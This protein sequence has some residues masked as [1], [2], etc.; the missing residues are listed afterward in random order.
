MLGLGEAGNFPAAVKAVSE[1]F[2]QKDQAFAVGIFNAGTNVA[3][4]I[5]PPVFVAL[6]GHYGWRACFLMT[7][8]VGVVWLI[9]WWIHYRRPAEHS[10]V[11]AAEL[12]YI[13]SDAAKSH[14]PP[15]GWAEALRYRE[16][17]GFALGKFFSDPVWW[18]YLSWLPPY[19]FDVRKL[20]L[21]SIGWALPVIYLAADIGSVGGGWMAGVLIRRGWTVAGARKVCMGLSAACMPVAALCVLAESPFA[22]I[23]LVSLATAAHQSWSANLYATT[24]DVFPRNAVASV[25]GIG[26]AVGAFGGFLFSGSGAG[27]IIQNFG[28]TP[29]FLMMGAFHLT[30]FLCVHLLM[31]ELKPVKRS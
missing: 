10:W 31:G 16:T 12:A 14:E 29:A 20:D 21:K 26:G 24:P 23:A 2:P 19:L 5:G 3:T 11:T 9:L 1:G 25:T 18:F 6:T 28:Y 4:M 22:A 30:G 17:W 13:H 27:F 8:S 15:V 7:A